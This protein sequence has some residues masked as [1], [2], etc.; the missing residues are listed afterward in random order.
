MPAALPTSPA[1]VE[2]QLAR[3][4]WD[5]GEPAEGMA[6]LI[7]AEPC[8]TQVG[9]LI[10]QQRWNIAAD[11]TAEIAR[12]TSDGR[13]AAPTEWCRCTPE[14][15][16]WVGYETWTALGRVAHGYICPDCRRL[17]QAG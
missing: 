13:F 6:A 10:V 16:E 12:L 1:S 17:L 7:L 15:R 4:D 8:A 11:G 14:S 3:A 5:A 9:T 2:L